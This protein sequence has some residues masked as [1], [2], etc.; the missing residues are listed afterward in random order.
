MKASDITTASPYHPQCEQDGRFSVLQTGGAAG[1]CVNPLTGETL[2]TA[3]QSAAGELT[4]PSWCELQQLRCR[5]DGSF[6]PLQCD[7][8]SCWCVSEDGQ[9]VA[10][11]RSLRQTG[12]TPSCDRPLCPAPTITHGALVC[13]PAADGRQSCDL[14]CHHGYQNSLPVSSFLCSI[15]SRQWDEG[16]R[17]LSGACQ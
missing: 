2:Q 3:S 16:D 1:W 14:V 13:H 10:G 7:V 17:P 12:R 9:E 4:C 15:K 6:D 11:T 8:T 5:P